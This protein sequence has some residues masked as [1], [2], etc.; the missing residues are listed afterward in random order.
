MRDEPG[1]GGPLLEG[2]MN[3]CARKSRPRCASLSLLTPGCSLPR[4][5]APTKGPEKGT[6]T[7]RDC[8]A[9]HQLVADGTASA[10]PPTQAE[11]APAAIVVEGSPVH[12][13]RSPG[14]Q[15]VGFAAHER[16]GRRHP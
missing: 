11:R 8:L 9:H 16:G 15:S 5:A 13:L 12:R 6:G 1:H 14:A 7:R 4:Y 3:T 10:G 2:N